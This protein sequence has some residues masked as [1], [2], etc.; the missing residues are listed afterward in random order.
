MNMKNAAFWDL[1]SEVYAL[2]INAVHY[3]YTV[4]VIDE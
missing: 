4:L 1:S 2:F 3:H